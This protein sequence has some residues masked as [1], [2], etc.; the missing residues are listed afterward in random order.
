MPETPPVR[1]SSLIRSVYFTFERIM[2]L[3]STASLAILCIATLIG[4]V[5]ALNTL[6]MT[7]RNSITAW[8]SVIVNRFSKLSGKFSNSS[9]FDSIIVTTFH[10]S[11]ESNSLLI[12]YLH[13]KRQFYINVSL[14]SILF[15]QRDYCFRIIQLCSFR[16]LK[17]IRGK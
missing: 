11:N 3:F 14:P 16:S 4:S 13:R 10:I 8:F 7:F 6:S 17:M 15:S 12:S 5:S 1:P 9:N 2:K